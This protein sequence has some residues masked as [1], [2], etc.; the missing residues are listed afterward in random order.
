MQKIS[1]GQAQLRSKSSVQ[2]ITILDFMYYGIKLVEI[3]DA[4]RIISHI[5]S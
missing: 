2:S 3:I 4:T 5:V 1:P